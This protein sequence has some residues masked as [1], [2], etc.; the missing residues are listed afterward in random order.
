M[1]EVMFDEALA[2]AKALD[3][4]LKRTGKP[5]GPLHGLPMSIKDNFKIKGPPPLSGPRTRADGTLL[6]DSMRP[7]ACER[8]PRL[9]KRRR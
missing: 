9:C 6:Q 3:E 5:V 2:E 4:E 7:S 1:T 8:Y